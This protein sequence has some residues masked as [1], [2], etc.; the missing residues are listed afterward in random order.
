MTPRTRSSSIATSTNTRFST[1]F[2]CLIGRPFFRIKE[3]RVW[4]RVCVVDYFEIK[5]VDKNIFR[6]HFGNRIGTKL[7]ANVAIYY[8]LRELDRS[9]LQNVT[10]YSSLSSSSSPAARDPPPHKYRKFKYYKELSESF[11]S[12]CLVTFY[13]WAIFIAE[14]STTRTQ[15]Y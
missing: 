6:L 11:Q 7:R 12:I 2:R 13:I 15:W 3:I 9:L 1:S 14:K 4:H 8:I 5:L 10:R